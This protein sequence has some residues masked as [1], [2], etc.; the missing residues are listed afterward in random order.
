VPVQLRP[1]NGSFLGNFPRVA[2]LGWRAVSGAANYR[3]EVECLH[4]A[5]TGQWNNVVDSTVGGTTLTTPGLPGDNQFRWR[6]RAIRSNG[7]TGSPSGWW[8]FTYET[9]GTPALINP[10]PSAQFVAPSRITFSWEQTAGASTYQLEV[11][12]TAGASVV[13][14]TMTATSF[15]ATINNRGAYQWRVTAITAHGIRSTSG[16]SPFSMIIIG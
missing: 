3:V 4:C 8:T 11:Q 1:G 12:T 7:Q 2:T 5:V 16:W 10:K 9:V 13:N 6:V 15:T 14:E